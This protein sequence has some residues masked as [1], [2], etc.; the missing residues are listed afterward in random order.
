MNGNL[1]LNLEE[2]LGHQDNDPA[3]PSEK[4]RRTDLLADWIVRRGGRVSAREVARYRVAGVKNT[5]E[6][7]N[8]LCALSAEGKGRFIAEFSGKTRQRKEMFVLFPEKEG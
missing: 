4:Q 3:F 6:A 5:A 1:G 2:I 8:L 7:R